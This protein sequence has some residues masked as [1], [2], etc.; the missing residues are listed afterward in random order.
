MQPKES[1]TNYHFIF[2]LLKSAIR[3]VACFFLAKQELLVA[4]L[5]FAAAETLGIIE[6]F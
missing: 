6:E 1:K 2:S 3:I 5:L 4:G